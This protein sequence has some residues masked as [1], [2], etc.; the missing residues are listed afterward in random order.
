[1][2]FPIRISEDRH[3]VIG[4]FGLRVPS[5]RVKAIGSESSE[6]IWGK[7]WLARDGSMKISEAAQSTRA[8]NLVPGIAGK[9]TEI[10]KEVLDEE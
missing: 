5:K 10:M 2:V 4:P 8:S 6:S 3:S 7:N 9:E 1:M